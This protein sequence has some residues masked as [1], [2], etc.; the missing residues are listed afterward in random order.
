MHGFRPLCTRNNKKLS[1]SLQVYFLKIDLGSSLSPR[2]NFQ[3]EGAGHLSG[4]VHHCVVTITTFPGSFQ[5]FD[6][7][8]ETERERERERE[9]EEEGERER[10][11]DRGREKERE[12]EREREKQRDGE[13]ERTEREREREGEREA[14]NLGPSQRSTRAVVMSSFT[15]K[16]IWD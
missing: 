2:C 11:R 10:G 4:E 16:R 1:L 13:I 14:R 9:R 8:R 6:R 15:C 7:E 12:R 3:W 5:A